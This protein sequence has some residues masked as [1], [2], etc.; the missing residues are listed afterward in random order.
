VGIKCLSLSHY[1][2]EQQPSLWINNNNNIYYTH[3][4]WN[5][6]TLGL[7][8][9]T[10]FKE[11]MSRRR[12]FTRAASEKSGLDLV[13][14]ASNHSFTS[15][16]FLGHTFAASSFSASMIPSTNHTK[17]SQVSNETFVQTTSNHTFARTASNH[18]FAS[19]FASATSNHTGILSTWEYVEE[20]SF[21]DD[22]D[23]ESTI[24]SFSSGTTTSLTR[25][26]DKVQHHLPP[27]P[28]F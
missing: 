2:R 25:K 14:A 17:L 6:P 10:K 7:L 21:E 19:S 26:L 22:Y 12:L 20:K 23:D 27:P 16:C 8:S 13:D 1:S 18:T 11:D 4:H 9:M 24:A 28:L 15:Y 5:V 3:H